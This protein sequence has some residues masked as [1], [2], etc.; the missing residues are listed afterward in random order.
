[1][2]REEELS[3]GFG[4]F[5]GRRKGVRCLC[6]GKKGWEGKGDVLEVMNDS[7]LLG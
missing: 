5:G 4:W 6:K 3:D 2:S 7:N 1:M